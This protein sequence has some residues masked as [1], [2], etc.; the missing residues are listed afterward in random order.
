MYFAKLEFFNPFSRSIKDRTVF[1]MLMKAKQRG[2][3]NGRNK[4]FEATSGNVGIAMASL[5]NIFG[6][7]FRAYLPRPTPKTTEILLKILGAEVIRTDFE[8]IDP[9]MVEFVKKE[10]ERN[11]AVNLNQFENEDNFEAHYKYTAGEIDEQLKSIGKKPDV[12]VAG[13][14]TSGH[15]AGLAKYFKE[16]YDTKIVG[17]VPA[18]GEKIPGI[19]RL[20]TKPKWISKVRIDEVVEITQKEAVEGC[21]RIARED[22]LLIGLSAGAVVKALEKV[23]ERYNGTAVL[24]FPDDGFKYVEAFER[25]FSEE[26]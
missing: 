21:M 6:V 2:E 14:G 9:T 22:G 25:Y 18:E 5:S 11:D 16:R 3:I 19:K 8:T 23:R 17:A 13:I 7:K 4:L 26:I 24:I 10:A 15:I 20:E 12:I 1:N